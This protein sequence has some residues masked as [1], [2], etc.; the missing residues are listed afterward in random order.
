MILVDT[1]VWIDHFKFSSEK[2]ADLLNK[3][4]VLIHPFIIGEL[5]LG[6]MQQRSTT[7]NLLRQ[8]PRTN[9][10]NDNEV[11]HFIEIHR[12]FGNGI[13]Y[14]DVHLLAAAHLTPGTTLWTLDK[15]LQAAATELLVNAIL[16]H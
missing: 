14:V 12:L 16:L 6:G 11:L 8:L 13:G 2:L 7:L 1:S 10:A 4:Q 5:S 15:R 3:K 9:V